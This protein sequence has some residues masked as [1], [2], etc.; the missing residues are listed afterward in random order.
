MEFI[1]NLVIN[2]YTFFDNTLVTNI[3]LILIAFLIGKTE[4]NTA[5]TNGNLQD[6]R[7]KLF[8][9][10]KEVYKL[11]NDVNHENKI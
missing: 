6:V 4:E 10:T 5:I 7:Q 2:I 9:L 1:D 8:K 3:I 11:R